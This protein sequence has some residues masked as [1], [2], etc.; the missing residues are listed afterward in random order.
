MELHLPGH[1]IEPGDRDD[2]AHRPEARGLGG[3]LA[4]GRDGDDGGGAD[5][6][7][8]LD[9]RHGGRGSDVHRHGGRSQDERPFKR[10]YFTK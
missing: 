8:G 3:R 7:G 6:V 2:R 5:V 4:G 1:L 9:G 10:G